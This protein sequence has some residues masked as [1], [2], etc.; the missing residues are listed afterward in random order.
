MLYRYIGLLYSISSN[1]KKKLMVFNQVQV[2]LIFYYHR[3]VYFRSPHKYTAVVRPGVLKT[4][5]FSIL[6]GFPKQ[7]FA[8]ASKIFIDENSSCT[9]N[10]K[11]F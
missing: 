5:F 10:Q 3:I 2:L 4:I 11:V 9:I 7:V 8:K 1:F 6:F